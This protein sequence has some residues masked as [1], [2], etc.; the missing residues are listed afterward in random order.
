MAAAKCRWN[1]VVVVVVPLR[2]LLW[3]QMRACAQ[4]GVECCKFECSRDGV[5]PAPPPRTSGVVFVSVEDAGG[6]T[7]M[8][9]ARHEIHVSRLHTIII[10]EVH[11][12]LSV[13]RPQMTE[14]Y[15][16]GHLECQLIGLTAS[17]RRSEQMELGFMLSR[18]P[19]EVI[20]ASTVR[21]NLQ[22]AA[23][24]VSDMAEDIP[25]IEASCEGK[26]DAVIAKR[27][28]DW[29]ITSGVQGG[30]ERLV[31]DV[32]RDGPVADAGAAHG[33]TDRAM[34]YCFTVK[35]AKETKDNLQ[36][37]ALWWGRRLDVALLHAELSEEEFR[38]QLLS[39][40]DG[41]TPVV[42]TTGVIGCGYDYPRVRLVLHKGLFFSLADYHQQSGRCGRDGNPGRCEVVYAPK[43]NS[44]W[45][46]CFTEGS[47][48]P[49]KEKETDAQK[50]IMKPKEAEE[51]RAADAWIQNRA[52]CRRVR[53]HQE[54]DGDVERCAL[55]PGSELC[56]VCLRHQR[57]TPPPPWEL[58]EAPHYEELD[59][60]A[61]ERG[62]WSVPRQTVDYDMR[63][64]GAYHR[65]LQCFLNLRSYAD[66]LANALLSNQKGTLPLCYL[67]SRPDRLESETVAHSTGQCPH[68]S[69]KC[70]R[71]MSS[72]HRL[73]HCPVKLAAKNK[74]YDNCC[75]MCHF[76]MKPAH[77]LELHY[78]APQPLHSRR[79][80]E[81]HGAKEGGE[82]AC[83]APKVGDAI[84]CLIWYCYRHPCLQKLLRGTGGFCQWPE[85]E[86][87]LEPWLMD[88]VPGSPFNNFVR[89]GAVCVDIYGKWFSRE[90]RLINQGF[91]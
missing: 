22:Y 43:W 20:R 49:G 27:L 65:D 59:A 39:W 8:A 63:G 83:I 72:R 47:L 44:W 4:A 12:L 54:M 56:D 33:T 52:E 45:L 51:L 3:K 69:D 60:A 87:D 17:L 61:V 80:K 9:W 76:P 71:C 68:A 19:L 1:A 85:Y 88:D 5:G 6:D 13:F 90:A 91:I 66:K 40:E 42:V 48:L 11:L 23:T 58:T 16:L 25:A 79:A 84:L 81:H 67:C 46:K 53:L 14:L 55:V 82:K 62:Q 34:V 15:R 41:V 77:G 73:R 24:N 18:S 78:G 7:F 32:G 31:E 50:Q 29:A 36:K 64:D 30:F 28:L 26:M 75:H 86:E 21:P 38:T 35:Q 57:E 74:T 70:L 10:D 89:V 37:I 2:M